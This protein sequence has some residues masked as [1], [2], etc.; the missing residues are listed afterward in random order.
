MI[1]SYNDNT[2]EHIKIIKKPL[3]APKQIDRTDSESDV[4]FWMA[5]PKK[6]EDAIKITNIRFK[7]STIIQNIM[8]FN[9]LNF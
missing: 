9:S 6:L 1:L 5:L 8:H 4:H 3:A 7:I 2:V